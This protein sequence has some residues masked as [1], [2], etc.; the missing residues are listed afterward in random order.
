MKMCVGWGEREKKAGKGKDMLAATKRKL[1]WEMDTDGTE[2]SLTSFYWFP[3]MQLGL[4]WQQET[5]PDVSKGKL[6]EEGKE[7]KLKTGE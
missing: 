2:V 5:P 7:R 6:F 1:P 3:T 4:V